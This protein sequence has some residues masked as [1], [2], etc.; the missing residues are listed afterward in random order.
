MTV[1]L[2]RRTRGRKM[3]CA[4]AVRL[5]GPYIDGELAPPESARLRGHLESCEGC[6]RQLEFMRGFIREVSSLP[7][8]VPTPDESHRLLNRVRREMAAP[9]TPKP[10]TRRVQAAAALSIL[11]VG[12]AVGVSLALWGGGEPAPQV[13]VVSTREEKPSEPPQGEG[14]AAGESHAESQVSS[15]DLVA[16]TAITQPSLVISEREYSP[17]DLE[18]FRN[19]IGTRL[20]FYSTYW[21]PYSG[22]PAEKAA[23]GQLQ[24]RLVDDLARQAEETGKD[25]AGLREAVTAALAQAGDETLL[26]CYAELARVEGREAWLVSASGPE[27]YLLFPD[28]QMPPALHLATRG[29]EE[30][31]KVSEALLKELASRLAPY[32]ASSTAPAL[33]TGTTTAGP[34]AEGVQEG[35]SGGSPPTPSDTGGE[36]KP[37]E[38]EEQF[39]SFLRDLAAQGNSLEVISALEGLNYR[40][41]LLLLQGDWA[42]LAAGG[43]DLADF[44]VPPQRLWA[45]DASS[46]EILWSP[47]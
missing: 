36:A 27:D 34:Q 25:S 44:L 12:T 35:A 24:Q 21:Y 30:S 40:Q 37:R 11:V 45:V 33:P 18:T 8:I 2:R 20:E 42:A 6:S 1:R 31:L 19:D 41:L 5:I 15:Q 7:A 38:A 32:Y 13:K 9:A 14:T 17:A 22:T 46:R 26:P 16:A 28:P 4:K 43:V 47:R 39:K 29:G 10:A 3:R 23:Y